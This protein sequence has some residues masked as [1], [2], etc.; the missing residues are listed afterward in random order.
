MFHSQF[1]DRKPISA[2]PWT[3]LLLPA[4]FLPV[5]AIRRA[6]VLGLGG[7]AIVRLLHQCVQPGGIVGVELDP[8]H[9]SIAR[10]F[11]GVTRHV[12]ELVQADAV[13]WLRRY[14]GPKFDLIID[15]LFGELEGEPVRAVESDEGWLSTLSRHLSKDGVLVMNFVHSRDLQDSAGV[16]SRLVTK[17]RDTAFR[18]SLQDYE[19][20]IGA[21]MRQDL[22]NKPLRQLLRESGSSCGIALSKTPYRIRRI[23]C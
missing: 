2:T 5:G 13:H 6:L 19:N 4:F 21:F 1:N 17:P 3:L 20:V 14:N 12:A 16:L 23:S 10:R 8:I 22:V 15:D 18:F 7:G 9:I 11:F